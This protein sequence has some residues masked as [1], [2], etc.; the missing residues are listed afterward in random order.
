MQ[1]GSIYYYSQTTLTDE[2][3]VRLNQIGLFTKVTL[4]VGAFISM[5]NGNWYDIEYYES[6]PHV[7]RKMLNEFAI[8]KEDSRLGG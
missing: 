4:N 5:Y 6:L 3:G 1:A 2:Q 7:Q 8:Q